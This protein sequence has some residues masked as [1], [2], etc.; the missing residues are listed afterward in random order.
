MREFISIGETIE[1][2][3]ADHIEI[4]TVAD[5]LLNIVRRNQDG[6]AFL[7]STVKALPNIVAKLWIYTGSRF[8]ENHEVC[9][10]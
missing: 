1:A 2:L 8:V 10:N 3:L 4:I 9:R 7:C 5:H 6:S